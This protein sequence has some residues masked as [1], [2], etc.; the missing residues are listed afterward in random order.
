[1]LNWTKIKHPQLNSYILAQF[2]A[3]TSEINNFSKIQNG[4][5][6]SLSLQDRPNKNN[7]LSNSVTGLRISWSGRLITESVKPRQTAQIAQTGTLQKESLVKGG[8]LA[9]P[10]GI[11]KSNKMVNL[12]NNTSVLSLTSNNLMEKGLEIDQS[13]F[14]SKNKLGTFTVKVWISS[15]AL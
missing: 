9:L 8:V 1:M 4:L 15:K 10:N 6:S 5:F 11:K 7:Y 2:L 14:T 13:S 3:K 12:S